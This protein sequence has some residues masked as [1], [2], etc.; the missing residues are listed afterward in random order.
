MWI[1]N[2]FLFGSE[3]PCLHRIGSCGSSPADLSGYFR[4]GLFGR[5]LYIGPQ[6]ILRQLLLFKPVENVI[7]I[8]EV[9]YGGERN[10]Q[11]DPRHSEQP[12]SYDEGNQDPYRGNS[13]AF[14]EQSG[15]QDISVDR[16]EDYSKQKKP[17]CGHRIGEHQNKAAQ[18]CAN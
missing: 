10:R 3:Q 1:R 9:S 7:V 2:L 16:L 11:K 14:T 13:E 18:Q 15:F 6:K 4:S 17:Q 5:H 12:A 8:E